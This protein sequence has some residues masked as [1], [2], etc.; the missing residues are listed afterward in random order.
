MKPDTEIV[1]LASYVHLMSSR[2]KSR[3]STQSKLLTLKRPT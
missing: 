3:P 1:F 2:V